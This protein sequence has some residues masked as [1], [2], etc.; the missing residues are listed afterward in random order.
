MFYLFKRF[1][2]CNR[3]DHL[4]Q[5]LFLRNKNALRNILLHLVARVDEIEKADLFQPVHRLCACLLKIYFWVQPANLFWIF[6]FIAF[7][8]PYLGKHYS[9]SV[10][11]HNLTVLLSLHHIR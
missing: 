5:E 7:V 8:Q 10:C 9:K 6:N 1:T 4:A 2:P 3:A 11:L